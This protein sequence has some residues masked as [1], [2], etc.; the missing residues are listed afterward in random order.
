ML[1]HT[2]LCICICAYKMCNTLSTACVY[3]MITFFIIIVILGRQHVDI[4]NM[5][6]R[7][8]LHF[9]VGESSTSQQA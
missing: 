6:V 9:V 3:A 2:Y 5:L 7:P 4:L 1:T 8:C